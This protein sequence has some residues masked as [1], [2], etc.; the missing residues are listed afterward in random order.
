MTRILIIN[1][2][3]SEAITE[4]IKREAMSAESSLK[5]DIKI[6]VIT[7]GNGPS[8]IESSNDELT[9]AFYTVEELKKREKN[10]DAAII[11]CAADPGI[12]AAKEA[13]SI[14]VVGLFEAAVHI[15]NI[16]GNHFSVIGSCGCEDIAAFKDTVRR[17]GYENRLASIKYLNTGVMGVDGACL[18]S[19]K[20]KI[21]EARNK[22]GANA[23][24][25]GCA[26]FAGMGKKLSAEC[27]IYV[28][29][30]IL[31]SVYMAEMMSEIMCTRRID[32]RSRNLGRI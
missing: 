10:Y 25:L 12:E 19:L 7:S 30:G 15:C 11:A 22:D 16:V 8:A 2:N 18:S 5:Q 26:A 20:E 13:L 1:P 29:D 24:I 9:A 31:E 23:V 6:D 3:S 17:Y 21:M 28:T 14:P 32:G 4:K 27:G